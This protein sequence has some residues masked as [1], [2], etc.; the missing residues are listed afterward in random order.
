MREIAEIIEPLKEHNEE[1]YYT[2]FKTFRFG[3]Q[4]TVFAHCSV[5]VCL[6]KEE[7]DKVCA[8]DGGT[9]A[10]DEGDREKSLCEQSL[11]EY[12]AAML[13][14]RRGAAHHHHD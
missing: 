1:Q 11:S 3:N 9:Y 10:L 4:T 8:F 13:H 5:Q 14:P 2:Q 6:D 12:F 7:C